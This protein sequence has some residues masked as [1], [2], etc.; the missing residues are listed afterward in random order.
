MQ[1]VDPVSDVDLVLKDMDVVIAPSL[2]LEAWG[3]VVTEA[4]IRGIP[5]IVSH[6]GE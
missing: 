2:W 6:L 3:I 1:V 4:M 5:T